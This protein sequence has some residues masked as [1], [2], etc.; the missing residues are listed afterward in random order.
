M[1]ELE[2]RYADVCQWFIG[3]NNRGLGILDSPQ[4]YDFVVKT[5]SCV[6]EL[7]GLLLHE[8][9]ILNRRSVDGFQRIEMPG[10]ASIRG[11]VRHEG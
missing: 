7:Q 1:R 10:G 2:Q 5:L 9:Q 4:R 11:E 6:M 3:N 8:L